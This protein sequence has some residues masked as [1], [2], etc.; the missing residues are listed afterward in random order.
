MEPLLILTIDEVFKWIS[1]HPEQYM[2][3]GG[4]RFSTRRQRIHKE[5]GLKCANP[6]CGCVG[7]H[8][9]LHKE[10]R[11]R[12]SLHLDL[13]TYKDEKP[14]LMTIDHIIPR[15]KGGC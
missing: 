9:I 10:G 2:E 7:T 5:I 8:Y 12:G 1:E 4:Y 3:H 11:V 13:F 6:N 15:S 14:M